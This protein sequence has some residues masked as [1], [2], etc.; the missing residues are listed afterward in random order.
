MNEFMMSISFIRSNIDK[1]MYTYRSG[2]QITHALVYVDDILLIG[3]DPAHRADVRRLLRDKFHNITEQ[4]TNKI[5]FL[6]MKIAK[7][8]N[9]NISIDQ[10]SMTSEILEEY[11]TIGN[12]SSPAAVNITNSHSQTP[13]AGPELSTSYKSLNMK[14]LYLA[15][16]TRPD[17]LFATVVLATRSQNPS[18][19]DFDRLHKILQYLNGTQT[20]CLT[21]NKDGPLKVNAHVDSS[22][23][24]HW[25]AKGHSGF[26]V[27]PDINNS[28][29]HSQILEAS[30]HR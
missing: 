1:C 6:G 18:Q 2:S 20:H 7:H 3:N 4:Q 12:S 14:L 26:A 28:S 25:D 22:F 9:G 23:N 24:L 27:F 19:I 30:N 17:I 29:Y 13:N 11:N 21:F 15:T 16:R 8:A 10:A 5:T